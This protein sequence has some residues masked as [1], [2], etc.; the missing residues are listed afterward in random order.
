[1]DWRF[2]VAPLGLIIGFGLG[3][4]TLKRGRRPA[5]CSGALL[6]WTERPMPAWRENWVGAL[7]ITLHGA[8]ILLV[9]LLFLLDPTWRTGSHKL[10]LLDATPF[11]PSA[12]R[13]EFQQDL[14]GVVILGLG[15]VAFLCG[16]LLAFPVAARWVRPISMCIFPE[17]LVR[18]PYLWPWSSYS[19]FSTDPDRHFIRF[20]PPQARE[21]ASMA[22]QPAEKEV[23]DEAV[24][25]LCQYLP[26]TPPKDPVPWPLRWPVFLSLGLAFVVPYVA[27]ALWLY[28]NAFP[29]GWIYYIFV[30]YLVY[31]LG[32]GLLR[33]YQR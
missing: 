6:H 22:W 8:G 31:L 24:A 15:V 23:Y 4:R 26:Q 27:C 28:L 7:F 16:I 10:F 13:A 1:M 11:M 20:Y 29:W 2:L 12:V 21:M 14:Y 19:Y 33:V 9:G 25:L 3:W 17:G 30:T 18:G 32:L 5:D